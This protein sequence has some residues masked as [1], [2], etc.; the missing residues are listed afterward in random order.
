MTEKGKDTKRI[1]LNAAREGFAEKG[2]YGTSM[3]FIVK[4]TGLSKGT[5]YWHFPGKWEIYKAV[6]SEEADR[7]LSMIIPPD[8]EALEDSG[9]EFLI[10][11]GDRL[12]EKLADDTL[13]RLL[14]VHLSLEA[15]RGKGEMIDFV[16]SLRDSMASDLLPLFQSIFPEEILVKQGF[17]HDEMV[18]MFIA[19]LH[20]IILNLELSISRKEARK[21]WHFLIQSLLQRLGHEE[22]QK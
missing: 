22:A 5:I 2:Y 18:D 16:A 11:R 1:L 15:M 8:M 10:S 21:I 14:F 13:C 9:M 17:S 20:G 4:K 12:I 3:D 19:I 6:L 7:I